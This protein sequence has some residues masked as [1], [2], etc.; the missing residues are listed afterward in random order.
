[1]WLEMDKYEKAIQDTRESTLEKWWSKTQGVSTIQ[2]N[3]K[4]NNKAVSNSI[5]GQLNETLNNTE[6][7][8]KRTRI[9]RSCAPVQSA[10][11]VE[12]DAEI[13]DDTD[14]YQLLLKALVDQKITESSAGVG[15]AGVRWAT[16][17]REAKTKKKVDT[18]ASKGRKLRYQ[19]HEKLQN[20]MAPNPTISW[21]ENQIE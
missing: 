18:K 8:V 4:L 1:M 15:A 12:E 6:R 14:F 17:M 11:E 10:K 20:F 16:A 7:L 9:P 3:Q 19:V 2:L 13:F 5:T 21:Q